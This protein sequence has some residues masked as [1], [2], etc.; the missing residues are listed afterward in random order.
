MDLK[1][2]YHVPSAR[3]GMVATLVAAGVLY[4][5]GMREVAVVM[6]ILGLAFAIGVGILEMAMAKLPGDDDEENDE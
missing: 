4:F 2:Q 5:I 6:L 1:K 3:A